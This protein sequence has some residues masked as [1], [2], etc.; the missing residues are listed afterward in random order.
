MPDDQIV[1]FDVSKRESNTP[2]AG[3]K[4]LVRRLRSQFKCQMNSHEI[5]DDILRGISIFIIGGPQDKF[6]VPEVQALKQYLESGGSLLITLGEG[7]EQK[8]GTN[9]NYLLEEFGMVVNN[10]CCVRTVFARSRGDAPS[11]LHPKELLVNDGIL[12]KSISEAAGKKPEDKASALSFVYPYGATLTVQKPCVPILSSGHL[13]YPQNRPI[14]AV[15]NVGS[16]KL[17]VLGSTSVLDDNYLLKEE[18]AKLQDALFKWLCGNYKLNAI[19]AEDP[20]VHDLHMLPD[21]PALAERVRCCLQESEEL[22]RDFSQLFD[23]EL[24]RF[25][26]SLIP[27]VIQLYSELGVKH[28]PLTLIQPQFETPLPP[29]TPAVLAP[30][31]RE[32]PPPALDMYDLDEQFA[33]NKIRLAQLTSKCM[34]GDASDLE[35]YVREAGEILD[36]KL[37]RGANSAKHVLEHVL[38]KIVNWRRVNRDEADG[39]PTPGAQSPTEFM[40]L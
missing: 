21:T 9:I 30:Q 24:F 31:F 5:S 40:A 37:P 20:D 33:S 18:N 1:L 39:V 15:C 7:G 22:P 25:D 23:D 38:K 11:Y 36:L 28:E 2:N 3:F 19:E 32:P 4:Q 34:T 12:N 8:S 14:G 13:A 16:G 27:E 26:V 10:D 17:M 29:L 35:Y 6:T